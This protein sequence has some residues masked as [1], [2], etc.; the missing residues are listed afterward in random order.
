MNKIYSK[1][2]IFFVLLILV[3]NMMSL[4]VLAYPISPTGEKL[5][6]FLDGLDVTRKW[7]PDHYVDWSSGT[8]LG[9]YRGAGTHCST[10]VAAAATRLGVKILK[11]TDYRGFLANAQYDWLRNHGA[12]HGWAQVDNHLTAQQIANQGCL[13]V[14]SYANPNRRRPGHI[15]IVRPSNKPKE[16]ISMNG[17][18]IIQAGRKNYNSAS[19][20]KG[21]RNPQAAFRKH[22][23]Q[24]YAHDTP[25]CRLV[26]QNQDRRFSP[27][28]KI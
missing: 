24:Y 28:K 26:V 13:V 8:V 21:F 15:A 11:P 10:F 3:L 27:A 18:Q 19:L 12:Q 9:K 4:T 14:I 25:F 1:G 22:R 23:L 5:N 16:A 6:D 2:K 17:P 7:L 20:A